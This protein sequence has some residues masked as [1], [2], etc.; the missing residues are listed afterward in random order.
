MYIQMYKEYG[1]GYL[2]VDNNWE[3]KRNRYFCRY[4]EL[5]LPAQWTK[6]EQ[7]FGHPFQK[8][9][10][11]FRIIHKFHKTYLIWI[12]NLQPPVWVDLHKSGTQGGVASARPILAV[13]SWPSFPLCC[14]GWPVR[15]TCPDRPV[16]AVLSGCPPLACLSRLSCPSCFVPAFLSPSSCVPAILSLQSCSDHRSYL[17]FT[18]SPVLAVLC[19]LCLSWLLKATLT[20]LIKNWRIN[21][22]LKKKIPFLELWWYG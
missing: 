10:K 15:P 19:R 14:P 6:R 8:Q 20:W 16:S 12:S 21:N 2:Y 4:F 18:A 22:K 9:L 3:T 5:I 1:H 7:T 17:F 13:M 11:P